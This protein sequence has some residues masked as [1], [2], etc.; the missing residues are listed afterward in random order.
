[1]NLNTTVRNSHCFNLPDPVFQ[2]ASE[3]FTTNL[4]TTVFNILVAPNT[5]I[6][7][8][9]ILVAIIN[10]SRLQST[11]NLLIASLALSD[12]LVGLTTQPGY[13]SYRLLEWFSILWLFT[14][15][16]ECLV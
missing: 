11:S 6:A 16:L 2:T 12:V 3:R 5:I 7:N 14:F 15:V 8:V 4:I 1:M 13:I 9:L 10:C